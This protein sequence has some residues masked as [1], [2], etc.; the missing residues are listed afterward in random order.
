MPNSDRSVCGRRAAR[1]LRR[2]RNRVTR[3]LF[4]F[5]I[6]QRRAHLPRKI[7]PPMSLALTLLRLVHGWSAKDL[8]VAAGISSSTLSQY[9]TGDLIL[10]RERLTELAAVLKAPPEKVELA[11]FCADLIHPLPPPAFSPVDPTRE[12][13]RV[14]DR[15]TALAV[16]E[17][18]ELVRSALLGEVRQDNV[19]RA[20]AAAEALLSRLK[21]RSGDARRD[22]IEAESELQDWALCLLLCDESEKAAANRPEYSLE[23]ADLALRVALRVEGTEAWRSALQGHAWAFVGN[24]RR[25]AS[26]LPA[27]DAAFA[28]SRQLS[29]AGAQGDPAGLL[30]PARRLDL[31]ASLRRAQR[32]FPEALKLHDQAFEIARPGEAGAI[33]L[34]KSDT[35]GQSGDYERSVETL[36]QA[37]RSIDKHRQ[38][39]LFFGLRFNLAAN[40]CH[41]GRLAEA[42]PIV[43]EVRRLAER[44]RNDL[45]LVRT[46]WLQGLVDAGFGRIEEAVAA[47]EQV[48]GDFRARQLPYDFALANLD[49][50]LLYR[51]QGRLQ[52]VKRLA[53]E[54]LRIFQAQRVHREA[55]AAV[56]LFSEAAEKGEVTV[57][58]IR[59]L[60]TYLSRAR[61]D[62]NTPFEP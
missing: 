2:S 28:A 38:P 34:N 44:L 15:A 52:E 40:L 51:E 32:R 4:S 10:T 18:A 29:K 55:L 35:L 37:T 6:I 23:L 11:L 20:F 53:G 5:R 47:L 17:V 21:A 36:E 19:R 43:D 16:R 9:E 31:E 57:D 48:R 25:V 39:R 27:S 8:A 46:R 22:L 62:P 14:V 3:A 59:R 41:L 49:L 1:R 33:L 24:A 45:D 61:N 50:A 26:D 56:R 13:R 7:P 60:Q 58:L 30:D 42:A 12:Q 54:M